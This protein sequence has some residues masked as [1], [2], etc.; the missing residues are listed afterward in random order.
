M[1]TLIDAM[2][3]QGQRILKTQS[4]KISIQYI[5]RGVFKQE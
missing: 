1:L 5:E 4:N 2:G 3:S